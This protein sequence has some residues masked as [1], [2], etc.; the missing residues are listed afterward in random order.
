MCDPIF[1]I[2]VS[3]CCPVGRVRQ[4]V[5]IH[6]IVFTLV[7]IGIWNI[8]ILLIFIIYLIRPR[9]INTSEM[10]KKDTLSCQTFGGRLRHGRRC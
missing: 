6:K 4:Y 9:L 10:L 7:S 8:F 2:L 3:Y 1:C 5:I